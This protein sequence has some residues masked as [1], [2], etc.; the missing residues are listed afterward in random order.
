M[1]VRLMSFGYKYGAPT[2]D[3]VLDMRCMENPYWVAE[4][5]ELSGLDAP[6]REYIFGNPNSAAYIQ[7]VE[8]MLLCFL[9]MSRQRGLR[10]LTVAVGCTGGRH[11]S[12]AVTE[13][14]GEALRNAGAETEIVHRDLHK[15][16]T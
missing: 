2:A 11:R 10:E 4:L 12:V 8:S 16:D 13:H 1:K 14:L 6:V 3:T 7:T 9:P 5:R 15:A